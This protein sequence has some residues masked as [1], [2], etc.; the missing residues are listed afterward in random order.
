MITP[1]PAETL[2]AIV[3]ASAALARAM[4]S[5]PRPLL[6]ATDA[7][8]ACGGVRLIASPDA[9]P[10]PLP[11]RGGPD[12]RE[13]RLTATPPASTTRRSKERPTWTASNV[14]RLSS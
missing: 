3:A 2:A 1:V 9:T 10:L 7:C 11:G 8:P 4:S 13:G 6:P 12:D 5:E 14:S